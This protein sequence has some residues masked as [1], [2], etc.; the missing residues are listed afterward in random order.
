MT[1][2]PQS[3]EALDAV[4]IN[5]WSELRAVARA[6]LSREQPGHTL[7][8]TALVNELYLKLKRS[9]N[10]QWDSQNDFLYV[11]AWAMKRLLVDHAR[12]KSTL[13]RGGDQNSLPAQGI[14]PDTEGLMVFTQLLERL[15][16]LSGRQ[17]RIFE[18][19]VLAGLTFQEIAD[20][21]EVSERTIYRD[22]TS[23]RA[24]LA[25]ELKHLDL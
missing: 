1:A 13:K 4:F 3:E 25:R 14:S 2:T 20:Q 12:R 6:Q 16:A 22:W 11:A 5:L 21:F 24:W 17:A 10:Q 9:P 8:P 23:A 18:Y 15:Q 19:H 7:Q